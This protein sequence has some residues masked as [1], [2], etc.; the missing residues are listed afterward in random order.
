MRDRPV[1]S[2]SVRCMS[3]GFTH[4]ESLGCLFLLIVS[5][6]IF[7]LHKVIEILLLLVHFGLFLLSRFG[8]SLGQFLLPGLLHVIHDFLVFIHVLNDLSNV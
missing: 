6:M 3:A 7:L 4:R 1:L 2:E 8:F 5:L